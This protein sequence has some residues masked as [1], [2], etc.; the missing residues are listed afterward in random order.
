MTHILR[1]YSKVPGDL[2]NAFRNLATATIY[3][4]AGQMGMVDPEI[5]AI[6]RGARVCGTAVT[7][8]CHVGD[9]LMLHKAVTVAGPGDILVATIG[10]HT[11]AGAWGEI[12]VTAAEARGI[13]GLVIDGAVRDAEAI[14]V[15]QFPVFAR[16]LCIGAT[17]KRNIGRINHP[18]VCGNALVEPGDLVIGDRDGVVVV[19]IEKAQEI[20]ANALAREAREAILMEKLRQQVTTLELLGLE[21]IL[22]ELGLTEEARDQG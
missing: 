14:E 5:R 4:A 15:H 13:S 8:E 20:L 16:G 3:E 2:V 10:E 17:M 6:Y 18:L 21:R 7:V 11:K 1:K 9:N 12:L 19:P 22:A